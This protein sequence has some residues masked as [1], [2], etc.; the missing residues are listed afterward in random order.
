MNLIG[1]LV[2]LALVFFVAY[3]LVFTFAGMPACFCPWIRWQ[4]KS[5][6]TRVEFA[7]RV[8]RT[9]VRSPRK[10]RTSRTGIRSLSVLLRASPQP[11]EL[12]TTASISCD[13]N[14]CRF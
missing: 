14:A 9:G 13:P 6:Y 4:G 11:D 5:T 12:Q 2:G 8:L 1:A 7:E 10:P 3:I